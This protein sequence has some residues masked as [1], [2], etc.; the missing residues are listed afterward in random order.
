M[1]KLKVGGRTH[2]ISFILDNIFFELMKLNVT[3]LQIVL[4]YKYHRD[5]L[6]ITIYLLHSL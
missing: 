2:Q 4:V 3:Y 6:Q 5:R 1:L